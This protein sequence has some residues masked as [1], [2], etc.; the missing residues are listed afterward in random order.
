MGN[1]NISRFLASS[2]KHVANLNRVLK[3]IKLDTFIDFIRSNHYGLV[4]TSNKVA[5]SSNLNIVESYIKNV[6]LVNTNKV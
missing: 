6:N 3:S 2:G 4:V 5:L 1:D